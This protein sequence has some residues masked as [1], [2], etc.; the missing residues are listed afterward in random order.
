MGVLL[1]LVGVG[2]LIF[3]LMNHL[4]GQRILA[5]PFKGTGAL[6]K[7]PTT[8]DPKGAISTEGKVVPPA[9]ACLSPCTKT[10]C[11]YYEV[12]VERLWEKVET[13]QDGTKT[14]KGS[15]TLSTVSGGAVASLDDGTGAVQVDFS[16]GADFDSLKDGYKKEL[17]GRG[18][19]SNVQ[20]GELNYELPV[21]SDS[22]KYTIGFKAT[23][24][25]VPVEGSFFVL[26][27]LE[28]SRIIK[29]GWRAMMASAK[30]REGLLGSVNKKKKFSF[31]GGGVATALAIPLMI[32]GP[33]SEPTPYGA[34]SYCESTLVDARAKCESNVSS[35]EGQHIGWTVAKAGTYEIE[36]FAPKKKVP[37]APG[38]EVQ[39]AG[40]DVI[41]S[42]EGGIGQNAKATVK[43][44]AGE[45]TIVVK[46]SDGY[47]VK[48][49][50]TYELEV[51]ATGAAAAPAV[52]AGGAAAPAA[53]G[54]SFTEEQL[55]DRL[56]GLNEL[57]G[58]TWCEGSFNYTFTKLACADAT[59]CTLG[60]TAKNG[61][62]HKDYTAS[63]EV[64]GFK[65]FAE[66]EGEYEGS[67]D[68]AVGKALGEWEQHPT[69]TVAMAAPAAAK[70]P[71][72][73]APAKAPK[74]KGK[75]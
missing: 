19:A 25:Y 16:K 8:S 20:F 31:I 56:A 6:A 27:K 32:W 54:G 7:D 38:I 18:W 11:L 58:D 66:G 75:K 36:V 2:V 30:G 52:A 57:C 45:H 24:R 21:L 61:E 23:E 35:K 71:A 29:P 10:P 42:G 47:M 15:D 12:K 9:E 51:R 53:A 40:G 41:G 62:T 67:L 28:G 70:V 65:T 50:F 69:S 39:K 49:G 48:G 59:R 14:V 46:P 37:F 68:E 64:K 5:A 44:E 1:L 13:T 63:V 17:N 55:K 33:K 22:E 74:G 26:G 43:V 4:K 3:G 60:F 73:A 34:S 72:K